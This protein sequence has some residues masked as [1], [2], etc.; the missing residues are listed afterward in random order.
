MSAADSFAKSGTRRGGDATPRHYCS[1]RVSR[2]RGSRYLLP[3]SLRA[4]D[5]AEG[6]DTAAAFA[7]HARASAVSV[8]FAVWEAAYSRYFDVCLWCFSRAAAYIPHTSLT[9]PTAADGTSSFAQLL[10]YL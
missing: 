8:L 9:A 3:V 7:R 6:S 2:Y 1:F 5:A 4:A 10:V